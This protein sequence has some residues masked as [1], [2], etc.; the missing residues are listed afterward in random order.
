MRWS[1]DQICEHL[2]G[3]GYPDPVSKAEQLSFLFFF[4]FVEG[5][6]A[7]NRARAR[8]LKKPR[9]PISELPRVCVE[10]ANAAVERKARLVGD[11]G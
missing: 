5:R 3:G 7:E 1:I 11:A 2:F 10:L 9:G 6:D 4:Y 8:F